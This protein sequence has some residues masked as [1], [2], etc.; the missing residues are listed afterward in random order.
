[1]HA[2]VALQRSVLPDLF[3][4]LSANTALHTLNLVSV[5]LIDTPTPPQP[6]R[7][8]IPTGAEA[9]GGQGAFANA[10]AGAHED[11]PAQGAEAGTSQRPTRS[12]GAVKRKHVEASEPVA[13]GA[14]GTGN[15]I[16]AAHTLA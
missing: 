2:G 12:S 14:E 10:A 4:S 8:D 15:P 7:D 16:G 3:T 5:C 6:P 13:A 9:S 1:M 11:E